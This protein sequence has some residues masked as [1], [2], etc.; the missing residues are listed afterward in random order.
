M[1]ELLARHAAIRLEVKADGDI[2]VDLHHTV[3]DTG[4]G[5]SQAQMDRLFQDFEQGDASTTRRYG[6]T[7]LGLAIVKHIVNRHRGRLV[8]TSEIGKGSTFMMRLPLAE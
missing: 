3:E 6:G 7:G 4:I 5:M 8:I 1:L 2:E